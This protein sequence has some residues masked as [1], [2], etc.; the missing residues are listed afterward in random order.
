MTAQL[1]FVANMI[2][3]NTKSS[4]EL[5]DSIKDDESV[6]GIV[7]SKELFN[8]TTLDKESLSTMKQDH[9]IFVKN[10]DFFSEMD[11]VF[12]NITEKI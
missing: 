10:R 8:R 3:H 12:K 6:I 7:P 11:S 4:H 2:K 1:Y 5:L 9:S